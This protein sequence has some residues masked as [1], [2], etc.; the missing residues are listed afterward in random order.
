MKK[1]EQAR[2][3]EWPYKRILG[4]KMEAN[5]TVSYR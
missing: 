4:H 3:Y 2:D 1:S 5:G